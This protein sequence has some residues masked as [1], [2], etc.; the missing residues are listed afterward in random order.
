MIE[1]LILALSLVIKYF[2]IGKVEFL[3]GYVHFV[4]PY[5]DVTEFHE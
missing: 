4:T 3:R 2:S 5:N 1:L